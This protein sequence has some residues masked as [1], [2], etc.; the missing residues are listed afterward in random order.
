MQELMSLEQHPTVSSHYQTSIGLGCCRGFMK[1]RQWWQTWRALHRPW[2]V[3]ASARS[4]E[5]L[6]I[7]FRVRRHGSARIRL[8]VCAQEVHRT[9]AA[10]CIAVLRDCQIMD[11]DWHCRAQAVMPAPPPQRPQ[12]SMTSST[13]TKL[14]SFLRQTASLG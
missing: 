6:R 13:T 9:A 8:E 7:G 1:M 5:T 12:T 3:R 11:D 14:Q 4:A 2:T 10:R